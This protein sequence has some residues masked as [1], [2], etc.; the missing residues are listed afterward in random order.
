[1]V[2]TSQ[3]P[4]MI[5]VVVEVVQLY[6]LRILMALLQGKLLVQDQFRQLY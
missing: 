5:G 3:N 2:V 1:M 6:F 4:L